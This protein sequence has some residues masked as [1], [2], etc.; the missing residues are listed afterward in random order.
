MYNFHIEYESEY[1]VS[2]KFRGTF[3]LLVEYLPHF[4]IL[5]GFV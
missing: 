3:L 5:I 4:N 1:A 2:C